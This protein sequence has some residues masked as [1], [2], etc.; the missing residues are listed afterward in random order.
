MLRL[1]RLHRCPRC[2]GDLQPLSVCPECK[3]T[4]VADLLNMAG[5]EIACARCGARNP[6]RFV[7]MNV[8]R[9]GPAYGEPLA[10]G[11]TS[12]YS[13]EEVHAR[14]GQRA[15]RDPEV[16]HRRGLLSESPNWSRWG[17]RAH[18]PTEVKRNSDAPANAPGRV[19][20]LVNGS[21]PARGNGRVNGLVNGRGVANAPGRVNGLVNGIGV[22]NGTALGTV[23]PSR[24]RLDPR[25]LMIGAAL[26]MAAAIGLQLVYPPPQAPEIS[27][28]GSFEDWSGVPVYAEGTY[29]SSPNVRI[30]SV[31]LKLADAS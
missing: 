11:C 12:W 9:T 13:Y 2:S 23:R 7:C 17:L 28:D 18:R 6:T 29:T 1:D 30:R 4:T 25:Y 22:P 27:I 5:P 19:N 15:P 31:S 3:S 20:G 24:G 21:G 14:V 26:L 10:P 16:S 8:P